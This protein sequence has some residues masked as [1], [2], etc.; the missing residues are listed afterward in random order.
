MG[1]KICPTLAMNRLGLFTHTEDD[2]LAGLAVLK[3]KQ[4]KPLVDLV[5]AELDRLDKQVVHLKEQKHFDPVSCLLFVWQNTIVG[6]LQ[7][8]VVCTF[9]I[10][11]RKY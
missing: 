2:I 10:L 11:I 5:R 7:Q 1:K 6:F 3:S 4:I 9:G 8:V